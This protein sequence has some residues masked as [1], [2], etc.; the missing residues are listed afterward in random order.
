MVAVGTGE[1]EEMKFRSV[2]QN[3]CMILRDHGHTQGSYTQE[4]RPVQL[5]QEGEEVVPYIILNPWEESI[6][7]CCSLI[8]G[9]DVPI[10]SVISGH[11]KPVS[12]SLLDLSYDPN[13]HRRMYKVFGCAKAYLL[14]LARKTAVEIPVTD[15]DDDTEI[16]PDYAP[17]LEQAILGASMIRQGN[18]EDGYAVINAAY[19]LYDKH[20]KRQQAGTVLTPQ[21]GFPGG[22]ENEYRSVL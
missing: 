21:L 18:R 5:L 10:L 20:E 2:L 14:V 22:L 1:Q 6:I 13:T 12:E 7:R 9:S 17:A 16:F 4:K 19:F 8:D 3:A 15:W 11:T